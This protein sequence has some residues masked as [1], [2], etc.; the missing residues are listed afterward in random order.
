[1]RVT[2]AALA[3]VDTDAGFETVGVLIVVGEP[4]T[5]HLVK[6]WAPGR[7]LF[8]AYGP[9][10][11]SIWATVQACDP[12]S[13]RAPPI[14]RP[15]SNTR[16]YLLN[17][18]MDPVPVGAAGELYI[19]GAGVGRGYLNRPELTAER[20]MPS[21]FVDNDRL[22]RTGDLARYLPDGTIEY[23]GRNDDQVKIRGFRI[24]LGEIEAR[25]SAHAGVRDAVVMARED[26]MG[27]KRLVAYYTPSDDGGA[28]GAEILRS[29]V[30]AALP[31]YMVP[32]AYVRLES[33]PLTPNGKLNRKAL[34][35][36]SDDAYARRDYEAPVGALEEQL[37]AIWSELLGVQCV[38]RHDS[39]F[40]LGGHSLLAV[41]L[42][43]RVREALGVE[44]GLADV[45]AVPVLCALAAR[46]ELSAA[47]V[48]PAI[49]AVTRDR[50]L[51]LSFAQQRLWV[52]GQLE[53]ASQAY[54]IPTG[55]RLSGKLD[56]H[57]LVRALHRIVARHES[58]RTRFA[59]VEGE[60]VQQF[61]APDIGFALQEHDLETARNITETLERLVAQEASSPFNLEAGPL[62]RGCLIRLGEGE[63]VLL[64]TMHHIVSDGWSIG[65]L[66]KELSRLYAIYLHGGEDDLPI[67]AI[68]YADYAAWQRRWLDGEALEAQGSYWK[69]TLSGAPV[70]MDLPTDYAR[71]AE[72]RYEGRRIPLSLNGRLSAQLRALSQRHGTT[73][74]MTLLAGWATVLSKLSGQEDLMIGT[75]VANRTQRQTEK[76][77]GYF[78]NTLALRLDLTGQPTV[79]QLLERTK[80]SA[81]AAQAHQD[82]P[83]EQVVELVR[84]ERSLAYS[85]LFQVMFAWQ[86]TEAF[87]LELPGLLLSSVE[88]E[89]V[90]A[91]FDLLLDLME[92]DQGIAGS[93]EYSTALF[94]QG[95]VERYGRYLVQ[96]LEAM[97]THEQASIATLS[98][99]PPDERRQLLVDWNSTHAAYPCGRFIHELFEQQVSET[100][101]A[102]AVTYEGQE[103]SYAQLNAQANRLAHHLRGMGVG[104]DVLVAVCVERSLTLVAGLLGVLKA[105]A[106][107]VPLDPAYPAERLAYMLADA[108]P[109]VV[110]THSAARKPLDAAL[111]LADAPSTSLIDMEADAGNWA[112][113][114]DCNPD[115]EAVGLSDSHLAYVIYTSGSTGQPKGVAGSISGLA[116]RL[117]WFTATV[118]HEHP[119]TA[120]KTSI[121]FVDSITEMLGA[122][123]GGGRLVIFDRRVQQDLEA[124]ADKL[125]AQQV[126]NLVIVPSHL[127]SLLDVDTHALQT[128]RN[129]ICSGEPLTLDL[130]DQVR[131]DYPHLRLFNFYGSSEVNGDVSFLVYDDESRGTLGGR[132]VIGRPISNTRIYV[133]NETMQ[134]VP[135]GVPGEL[136]VGGA[137][138][139]RGYLNRPELTEERFLANPFVE[140]D[141]LYRTGDLT[142][143]LPDG[144]IEFLGRL[145]FQVKIRGFR[146]ELGEVEARLLSHGG[147]RDTVVVA[148]EDTL[149]ERRLVAYY[150]PAE[151]AS[152]TSAEELRLHLETALPDYMV[153]TAYVRLEAWPLTSSGKLDRAALPAPE[154]DA[155]S[156]RG[157]EAPNGVLEGQ[158]AEIWSEVLGVERIGRNSNFFDLGGHSL[159]AIQLV[160]RIHSVLNVKLPV[161][162]PFDAP[163]VARLAALCGSDLTSSPRLTKLAGTQ[164]APALFLVPTVGAHINYYGLLAKS[165][166]KN[167]EVFALHPRPLWW[168]EKGDAL[169]EL[170]I[171]L[172]DS[173]QEQQP[174]GPYRLLGWSA[175]G[176]IALAVAAELKG[177]GKTLSYTGL[178]DMPLPAM[179][180]E[181]LAGYWRNA[182]HLQLPAETLAKVPASLME[183]FL[184]GPDDADAIQVQE[185]LRLLKRQ[186]PEVSI[187]SLRLMYE[188]IKSMKQQH[189]RITES[190]HSPLDVPLHI[191]WALKSVIKEYARG[192]DWESLS[193][194]SAFNREDIVETDHASMMTEPYASRIADLI[195]LAQRQITPG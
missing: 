78:V 96:V 133:L 161:R 62:V 179:D 72:P 59:L 150:T 141:R 171:R 71:P 40:E 125:I 174:H 167:F 106:V 86:N 153:P 67:P 32:T 87:E 22:Y 166:G 158:L 73:L 160:S 173:I 30:G 8:N 105:G 51:P 194:M 104:P 109:A 45:F 135:I 77:I 175:G 102:I 3:N 103:L 178:L 147:V 57:A 50:A 35:A 142:R 36:P 11:A 148:R 66:V 163:T 2:P 146:I 129:L 154:D 111:E 65:V 10:E 91:K 63:H 112:T 31:D 46:A 97:V 1:M 172:A 139:A 27:G 162:A 13:N 21:P 37:A 4:P 70:S 107:Y 119:V 47:N 155:Y 188:Q 114:G 26:G 18:R 83:F 85:P 48:L 115:A 56:R 88:G 95:T 44:L 93:L 165:L 184:D 138:V 168:R 191:C 61:D 29:H 33:L 182:L 55:L 134:P 39:F 53:G 24:E 186:H 128:V 176:R 195:V 5:S 20:F 117:L 108:K 82:L 79:A 124:M 110:L 169:K 98:M 43:S 137:A 113:V 94:S 156:Q 136:Y 74:F 159:S 49:E 164:D 17:D 52:L 69:R 123:L 90:T 101:D 76:L 38:G 121:G 151:D 15:I 14:G 143:Y 6:T 34:P 118:V 54:H 80:A 122:L 12:R 181:F 58:L 60:P 84:P 9:S 126:T 116:N 190:E 120:I 68:Q 187:A 180:R 64:V 28:V 192:F 145:D 185:L 127:R 99:L 7:R 144:R 183:E 157:Y 130:V 19:G 25:L 170:A 132:S 131:S 42:I 100:P 41:R 189:L 89:T 193:T 23:M 92:T 81:V 16:V 177:R 140:G 149:G 75:P 152:P